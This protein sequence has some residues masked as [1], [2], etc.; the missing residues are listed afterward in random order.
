[1]GRMSL[2]ELEYTKLSIEVQKMILDAGL[3]GSWWLRPA[4]WIIAGCAT[5]MWLVALGL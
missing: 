5:A 4:A 2:G 3:E 1:M